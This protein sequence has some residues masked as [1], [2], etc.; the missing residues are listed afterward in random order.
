MYDCVVPTLPQM[1]PAMKFLRSA[2]LLT[3]AA[4]LLIAG[5]SPASAQ[6][7][8]TDW[9]T[10]STD[11]V[12]G[13]MVVDGSPINVLFQGAVYFAQTSC[14]TNY[15]TNP[16]I[17]TGTGVSTPPP[18]CE[19]IALNAGGFK[20][21]TFSQAVVNPVIALTS[22][23][24]QP[25]ITFN[26]PVEVVNQGRGYWGSGSLSASG[27]TL[28]ASGEAHGTIRLVGTYNEIS[29]TDGDE[30]WHGLTVGAES[31]TVTPE[32]ASLVLLATGLAGVFGIARRRKQ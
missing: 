30:G 22:W 28:T 15:W 26:G 2:R 25:P 17:Y 8:W 20:S 19:M 12:R 11:A 13:I 21:I 14:G 4:S 6:M 27:N 23:N 32:P 16:S 9:T 29:F 10:V 7:G 24:G 3:G 31:S 18:D 1:T 5:A